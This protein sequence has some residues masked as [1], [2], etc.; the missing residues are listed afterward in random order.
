MTSCTHF[1]KVQQKREC[2][3]ARSTQKNKQRR[4][5]AWAICVNFCRYVQN[6]QHPVDQRSRNAF[7]AA[8]AAED[9]DDDD[10]GDAA[11]IERPVQCTTKNKWKKKIKSKSA[12]ID[13]LTDIDWFFSNRNHCRWYCQYPVFIPVMDFMLTFSSRK[14]NKWKKIKMVCDESSLT[15]LNCSAGHVRCAYVR[16]ASTSIRKC[17]FLQRKLNS[18]MLFRLLFL[19]ECDLVVVV[20]HAGGIYTSLDDSNPQTSTSMCS[21]SWFQAVSCTYTRCSSNYSQINH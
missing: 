18:M 3:R 14:R 13:W 11:H 2:A 21:I 9:D 12:S 15:L 17:M 6:L 5:V 19:F 20:E 8:V 4:N 7:A 10:D 1:A 16:R